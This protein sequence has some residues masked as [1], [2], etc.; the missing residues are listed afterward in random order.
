LIKGSLINKIII[1]MKM[2]NHQKKNI[3]FKIF[4][5]QEY[6]KIIFFLIFRINKLKES[7]YIKINWF[8]FLIAHLINANSSVWNLISFDHFF[9]LLALSNYGLTDSKSMKRKGKRGSKAKDFRNRNDTHQKSTKGTNI[10]FKHILRS[11]FSSS[12]LSFSFIHWNHPLPP[13]QRRRW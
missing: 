11:F 3:I 4:F 9:K 13:L 2:S 6:I 10:K 5:I 12:F 8:F 1:V 7:K